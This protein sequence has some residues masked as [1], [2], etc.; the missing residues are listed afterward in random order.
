V[1]AMD[2]AAI[3]MLVIGAIFLWGGVAAA[4]I[5]YV[6]AARRDPG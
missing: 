5:H 3:I 1:R 2:T 6:V 4:A